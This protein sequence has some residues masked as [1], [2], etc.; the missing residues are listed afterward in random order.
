MSEY[1]NMNRAKEK[2]FKLIKCSVDATARE[3]RLK[4]TGGK[5][6][7]KQILSSLRIEVIFCI[8]NEV[9]QTTEGRKGREGREVLR[10]ER[11][12]GGMFYS[13]NGELQRPPTELREG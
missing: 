12:M 4:K 10:G 9:S 11:E 6:V 5:W 3:G 7:R 1:D 8:T 2:Y 13:S